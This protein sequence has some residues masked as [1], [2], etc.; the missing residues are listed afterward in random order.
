MINVFS[1]VIT[2]A[3]IVN[4][5]LTLKKVILIV[6]TLQG[7]LNSILFPIVSALLGS[8]RLYI[9]RPSLCV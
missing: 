7:I 4:I 5:T 9:H 3:G 1:D 2:H 8:S 6:Q